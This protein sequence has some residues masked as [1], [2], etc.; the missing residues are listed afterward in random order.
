MVYIMPSEPYSSFKM[1]P[2]VRK[3]LVEALR[4]VVEE[5]QYSDKVIEKIG[6][7]NRQFGSRDRRA[8]AGCLYGVV[9]NLRKLQA[10]ADSYDE[11]I[12]LF[13]E[14]NGNVDTANMSPAERHSVSDA[15]FARMEKELG[16]DATEALLNSMDSQADVFI[17]PNTLKT[18][19]ASLLRELEL[20][21]Y[22][23][24]EM[25][26]PYGCLVLKERKNLFVSDAYKSGKLEVQ[27][28]GSQCLPPILDPQPGDRVIDAC[29]GAGGKTLQMAA[30]MR[31][32]GKLIAMD[33]HQWKLDELRKRARRAGVDVVETKLIE[34]T[35]SIKRLHGSADKLLLDVPCTGTGVIKRKPDTKL[36][37]TTEEH[38]DLIETQQQILQSY[39]KMLKP[40]GQM[41]YATCSIFPSENEE[42]IEK[43][44]NA[45]KG[46]WKFDKKMNISPVDYNSDGFFAALLT[47]QS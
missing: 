4:L 14:S 23:L 40:G 15:L 38:E 25:K 20:D 22:E 42:Q 44:L 39:S 5:N 13:L 10:H 41:L 18:D 16:A 3:A 2:P 32:K 8:L 6:K 29:A 11:V 19:Q 12:D 31:N 27:D 34:N 45:A 46:D 1:H 26:E 9:R 36:K 21:G 47:K 24:G 7:T 28:V 35:K 37:Y 43:F 30:M 33:I 17:R